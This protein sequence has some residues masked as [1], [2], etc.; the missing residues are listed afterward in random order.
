[1]ITQ[2]NDTTRNCHHFVYK[3]SDSKADVPKRPPFASTFVELD[4]TDHSKKELEGCSM[5]ILV[6]MMTSFELLGY[7]SYKV[8]DRDYILA[9]E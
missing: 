7:C 2:I 6:G 5:C 1:M 4:K 8:H 9:L 3:S